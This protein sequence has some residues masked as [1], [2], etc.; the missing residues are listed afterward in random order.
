MGAASAR[1][2]VAPARPASVDFDELCEIV[3]RASGI[4]IDASKESLVHARLRKRLNE[5]GARDVSGYLRMLRADSTGEE[6]AVLLDLISTNVTS[7]FREQHH[8]DHLAKVALPAHQAS[9]SSEPM[10]VWS[11]ACSSGEEPYS[12]AMTLADRLGEDRL[13]RFLIL[14]TDISTRMVAAASRGS[15][16]SSALVPVRRDWRETWFQSDGDESLRVEW[17]LRDRVRA[18][19]LNLLDAWPMK[20]T[21]SAIFCRNV[22]IYFDQPTCQQLVRRFWDQLAPGGFL[23]IGHSESLSQLDHGFE[24]AGP[25]IYRRPLEVPS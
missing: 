21:F 17:R 15:F 3:R 13:R 1:S 23:Y 7:F 16:E 24:Y 18:R 10:R 20:R 19:H 9:G 14:A 11:A 6:T 4:K 22:L 25:T 12:I 2:G 5:T 8:F